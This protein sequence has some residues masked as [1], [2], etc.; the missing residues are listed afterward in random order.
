MLFPFPKSLKGDQIVSF[1]DPKTGVKIGNGE[2]SVNAVL[3][4]FLLIFIS[5]RSWRPNLV[6]TCREVSYSL[7]FKG[8]MPTRNLGRDAQ[9]APR[10]EIGRVPD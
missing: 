1:C 6:K 2:T 9:K 3:Q 4:V 7:V 10:H 8:K 5:A